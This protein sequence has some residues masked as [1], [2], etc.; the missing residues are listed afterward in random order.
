M[1]K[2]KLTLLSVCVAIPLFLFSQSELLQSDVS[3]VPVISFQETTY[4]FGTVDADRFLTH[5]FHYSNT[6]KSGLIIRR[7]ETSDNCTVLSGWKKNPMPPG[8]SESI[9]IVLN[10]HNLKN[11]YE[12]KIR[13]ICNTKKG[14]ETLRITAFILP[15]LSKNNLGK[16]KLPVKKIID[17]KAYKKM[18]TMDDNTFDNELDLIEESSQK[19]EIEAEEDIRI[20]IHDALHGKKSAYEKKRIEAEVK[21]LREK[22]KRLA[23]REEKLSIARQKRDEARRKIRER[24]QKLLN[25]PRKV[26]RTTQNKDKIKDSKKEKQ[27]PKEN[28]IEKNRKEK[29]LAEQKAR[30][31]AAEKARLEAERQA[32]IK[33]LLQAE[34][35]ARKEKEAAEQARL[36]AEQKARLL[37]ERLAAE[38]ATI[39]A[40]KRAIENEVKEKLEK[41]R[42]ADAQARLQKA[43][44]EIALIKAEKVAKT[45]S[46]D[47]ENK[48]FLLER[49][50]SMKRDKT[51]MRRTYTKRF[52]R[53][54]SR[55]NRRS[56]NTN[57]ES[58][59]DKGD[60]IMMY[61]SE[62]DALLVQIDEEESKFEKEKSRG[63][64]SAKKLERQEVLIQNLK[65]KVAN[66]NFIIEQIKKRNN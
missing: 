24:K 7:I 4:D 1:K 12:G 14:I 2:F 40:E 43:A 16:N 26:V 63:K 45:A 57:T 54:P 11:T 8:T 48:R 23:Q 13:L 60:E 64:W 59:T 53:R 32:Q 17:K 44:A 22:R 31:L 38:N 55:R 35:K 56:N 46:K 21:K 9:N 41:Q 29:A 25:H 51:R 61:Q 19:G 34:E 49:E 27:I 28:H 65:N 3:R 5:T 30:E 62:I 66:L 42:L 15:V 33:A 39:E 52:S 6:G 18:V 20:K 58:A 47:L 50:A 36:K 37:A 10:T